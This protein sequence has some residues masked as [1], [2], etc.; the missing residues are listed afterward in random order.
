MSSQASYSYCQQRHTAASVL[1]QVGPRVSPAASTNSQPGVIRGCQQVVCCQPAVR[2]EVTGTNE[3]VFSSCSGTTSIFAGSEKYASL[4]RVLIS[5]R[6]QSVLR[7]VIPRAPKAGV[8]G[9]MI[10]CFGLLTTI[11][12]AMRR[13]MRHKVR[14]CTCCK[15]YGIT[16]CTLCDGGGQVPDD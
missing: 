11:A 8:I 14:S 16:R 10:L 9:V 4:S 12:A 7:A 6:P 15:G 5:K 3:A 1:P 13:A 2:F